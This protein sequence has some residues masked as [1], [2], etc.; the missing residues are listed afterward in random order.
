MKRPLPGGLDSGTFLRRH[1][2]KKPLLVRGAFPGFVDPVS[3]RGVLALAAER[4]ATA[5]LVRHR[6]GRWSLEHGP[7]A[8]S[9]FKQLPHRNWTVLVQDTNYF[10][11][12]AARLLERFD[13][14]PHARVD[15]LMVSYAAPGGTVG[16]HVDSYDVFLL[17]GRGSRRWQISRSRDHEF[18]PGLPLK[19]LQRFVPDEEWV[20]ESGD[21]LY[22]PPGVPHYGVALT[23][24]LTWSVGFR[25][26]ADRELMAA[27]L[28]FLH[29]RLDPPGQYADPRAKPARHAGEIP[30]ALARH[31]VRTAGRIRWSEAAAREFAGRYLSETKPQAVFAVPRRPLARARFVAKAER[32]GLALDA[33]SR[34]LFS[35]SIFFMN[36]E[37]L[38]APPSAI[39]RLRALADRRRLPG[40]LRAGAAFWDIAYPWYTQGFLHLEARSE[41]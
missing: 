29:E 20:L 28:D 12:A 30:S 4:D 39:E 22:L 9:L 3:V 8:P 41:S 13:F 35:G 2:Q 40:P 23:E 34:L 16:P 5:R 24:C 33:R 18:R 11:Q 19:I 26:P 14:I 7:F 17:Q 25:A 6:A 1:W 15:D 37:C 32:T 36:G 21:L 10:S 31:I 27:F 38:R